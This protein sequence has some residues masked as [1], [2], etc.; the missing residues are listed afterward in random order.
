MLV[1]V[2]QAHLFYLTCLVQLLARLSVDDKSLKS[3]LC[4]LK[5]FPLKLLEVVVFILLFF[6]FS[7]NVLVPLRRAVPVS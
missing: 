1:V 3:L 6:K 4:L 2:E 7:E 5:S